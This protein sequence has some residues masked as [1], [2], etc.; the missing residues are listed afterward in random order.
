MDT[1]F[2]SI[3]ILSKEKGIDPQIVFAVPKDGTYLVRT[4]GFPA[5]P[6]AAIRFTGSDV[7]IYR[8]TLTTGGFVDHAYPLA[9][10]RASPGAARC[11]C[12]Q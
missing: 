6:D 10:A 3:E 2:Q 12:P 11:R 7:C 8:L 9:V 4:F 5:V 1:I